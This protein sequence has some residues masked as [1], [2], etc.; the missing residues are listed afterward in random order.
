MSPTGLW[1]VREV[2]RA[3]TRSPVLHCLL[4]FLSQVLKLV[5]IATGARLSAGLTVPQCIR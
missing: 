2:H 3:M 1:F 4:R 5:P